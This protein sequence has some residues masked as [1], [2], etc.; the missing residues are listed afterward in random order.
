MNNGNAVP[1][2]QRGRSTERKKSATTTSKDKL[3]VEKDKRSES[4]KREKERKGS[5]EKSKDRSKDRKKRV[6]GTP[7]LEKVPLKYMHLEGEAGRKIK[8]E[9]LEDKIQ[10]KLTFKQTQ[11]G[12]EEKLT[13]EADGRTVEGAVVLYDEEDGKHSERKEERNSTQRKKL[14][15]TPKRKKDEVSKGQSN[16]SPRNKKYTPNDRGIA[17]RQVATSARRGDAGK[18]EKIGGP[19][20]TKSVAKGKSGFKLTTS[21]MEEIYKKAEE[22]G[23]KNIEADLTKQLQRSHIGKG[24]RKDSS[25]SEE[26]TLG[27]DRTNNVQMEKA[28]G[29]EKQETNNKYGLKLGVERTPNPYKKQ[30]DE[31]TPIAGNKEGEKVTYAAKV[32]SPQT[33][34]RTHEKRKEQYDSFFEVSFHVNGLP[35]NPSTGDIRREQA[36][37]LRSILLRAKEVDRK[38]KI[39]TWDDKTDLP[40]IS[41]VEDIPQGNISVSAYLSPTWQ[42]VTIHN[43]RN[44]NWR[45]RITTRISRE[46]FIHLWG[47]SKKE[48]T[49]TNYVTLRS[50]PI[51]AVT[52]HA[53]GFFLNSSDGQL[54]DTLEEALE[55]ELGHKVGIAYKPA[56]LDRR[57]A[58]FFWRAAKKARHEAPEFDKSRRF[59][60]MAPMVMQIYTETREQALTTAI[61]LSSKYGSVDKDGMY[62]RMP[63]G[64]R[65]RFVAAHVYLD[66]QGRATAASLFKQQTLF[67]Q[68]E[69]I[70]PIPI[71][72]PHQK[73]STQQNRTMHELVMDLKDPTQNNEPYFRNMRKKFHWNFKTNEWEVS[74]HGGMYESAAKVLRK[75]KEAMTEEYGEQVGDAIMSTGAQE[76]RQQQDS[77]SGMGSTGISIATD[78]RYLNGDA[79]FIILGLEKLEANA[80]NQ[81]LAEIRNNDDEI[82]MNLRST[83]SDM[84]GETGKTV[85]S[86]HGMDHRSVDVPLDRK[87]SRT[88]Q[89]QYSSEGTK[90]SDDSSNVDMEAELKKTSDEGEWTEVAPGKGFKPTTLLGKA[91]HAFTSNLSTGG[92]QSP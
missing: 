40:T 92:G 6:D 33:L 69:V 41:K 48:F 32:S 36:A 22:T 44:N 46:E 30:T 31:D 67:Q 58:D 89:T 74:I 19:P 63:D 5:R 86:A 55:K 56:A 17:K 75:F 14:Q 27:G 45:V 51:Q 47:L 53:A 88:E 9:A 52:Q 61:K 68:H 49:K 57:A 59:F 78:D 71:R 24:K 35:E 70:T 91:Y 13:V 84:S 64:T 37:Q 82:T 54:V 87:E 72:D 1:T 11:H 79:Q 38:A 23:K 15:V 7:K 43:R 10:Q 18:E 34:I 85:P 2:Q 66:M 29:V 83:T 90:N 26:R 21:Y 8:V 42:G 65:M 73:F 20:A 12:G 3:Q 16:T 80:K 60:K 25:R 4:R 62:P 50:A 39:N 81:T 76:E 28:S 77:L